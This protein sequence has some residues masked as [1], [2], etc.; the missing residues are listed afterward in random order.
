MAGQISS[1]R[2]MDDD[3]IE[4]TVLKHLLL[5]NSALNQANNEAE[6]A[7]VPVMTIFFL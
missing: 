6:K 2:V 5:S 1:N 7:L 3:E 4:I